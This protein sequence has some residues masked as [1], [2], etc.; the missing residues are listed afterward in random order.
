MVPANV[1]A[2]P[3]EIPTNTYVMANMGTFTRPTLPLQTEN[4]I[5]RTEY[6]DADDMA[7]PVDGVLVS[8]INTPVINNQEIGQVAQA[9]EQGNT[10]ASAQMDMFPLS[11]ALALEIIGSLTPFS[12]AGWMNSLTREEQALRL[13]S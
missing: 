1:P 5:T 9:S 10:A 12:L 6:D 11:T 7:L 13:V 3:T 4:G 8:E 2:E